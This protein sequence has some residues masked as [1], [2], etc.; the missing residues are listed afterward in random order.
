MRSTD[1]GNHSSRATVI[2]IAAARR[3]DRAAAG[4]AVTADS[5]AVL[6][7][8]LWLCRHARPG[9]T[10]ADED[11]ALDELEPDRQLDGSEAAQVAFGD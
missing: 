6:S 9:T 2:Q 11:R 8:E 3:D 1:H 5:Q 10:R 7:I 4:L